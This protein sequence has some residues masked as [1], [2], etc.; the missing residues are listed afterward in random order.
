VMV[1]SATA[2][3]TASAAK[4]TLSEGG[5]VLGPEH[6]LEALGSNFYVETPAGE[7]SCDRL[8]DGLTS[9]V[10][11]NSSATDE[12][13]VLETFLDGEGE[14]CTSFRGNAFPDLYT[15][16]LKLRANGKAT[17]GAAVLLI[18]FELHD[19]DCYYHTK[20][21]KGTNTATPTLGPLRLEFNQELKLNKSE[22]AKTCPKEAKM[23]FDL[24][25][26]FGEEEEPVEEQT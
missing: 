16:R 23:Y 18:I 25:S 19:E 1:M 20:M 24:P 5:V 12:L 22:S 9:Y 11:T 13:E 4:L 17:L 2:T 8:G 26:V 10:V 14:H 3:G 21:L 7:I 6:D 15:E